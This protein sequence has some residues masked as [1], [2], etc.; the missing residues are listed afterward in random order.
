MLRN[1]FSTKFNLGFF[2]PK[3]DLCEICVEYDT[4][5]KTGLIDSDHTKRQNTMKIILQAKI[6]MMIIERDNDKTI[7]PKTAVVCV[8]LE[9]V[10]TLPETN[11]GCAFY[12][13]K[14]NCY[15]L[16]LHLNLNGQIYCAIWNEDLVGQSGND[17]G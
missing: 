17:L 16:T 3:K 2:S 9:N 12:K 5:S 11:V 4:L 10:L 14:L 15:N 7:D 8:D 1:I 13:R 6:G